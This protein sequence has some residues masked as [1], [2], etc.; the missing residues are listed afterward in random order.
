[1]LKGLVNCLMT[2]GIINKMTRGAASIEG[3]RGRH[4]L[5]GTL[6]K[7][8][9]MQN[10]KKSNNTRV[11]SGYGDGRLLPMLVEKNLLD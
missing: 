4:S 5:K 3:H 7:N 10:F 9:T 2:D 1:M 8:H 11:L 6:Q